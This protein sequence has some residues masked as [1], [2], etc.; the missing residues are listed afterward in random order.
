MPY[1]L[2]NAS[3]KRRRLEKPLAK[4]ISVTGKLVSVSNCLAS[5]K[6]RVRIN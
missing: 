6:R 1:R 2:L 4:A 3:L 5:N